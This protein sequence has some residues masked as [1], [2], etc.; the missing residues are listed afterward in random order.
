[1]AEAS[2]E[3]SDTPYDFR[4]Y[5]GMASL[6][7]EFY[8]LDHMNR[9]RPLSLKEIAESVKTAY[10]LV[11]TDFGGDADELTKQRDGLMQLIYNVQNN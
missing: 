5:G 3:P 10:D 7:V 1:M 11:V 4:R 6:A 8:F 2:H 9:Q